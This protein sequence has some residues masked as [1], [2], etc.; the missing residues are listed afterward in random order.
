MRRAPTTGSA[1]PIAPPIGSVPEPAARQH[2]APGVTAAVRV[3]GIGASA[4]GLEAFIDLV[5]A[6]PPQ[7]GLALVLIQHL[8]PHRESLLVDILAGVT[9]NRVREV[10]DGMAIEGDHV[11]VIPPDSEMTVENGLLRLK[12]RASKVPHRPLDSFFCS[13]AQDR[14]DGGIGVVL[15]GNDTDGA[16]GLQAIRDAGGI[17][18]AQT[19]GSARYDVMPRAAAAAADFVLPPAGIAER[20]VSLARRAA[21]ATREG[22]GRPDPAQFARILHLL[23]A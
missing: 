10:A 20:L 1:S 22:N 9:T 17:T 12:P 13:L 5:S 16:F 3:V 18:F 7:T 8:D 11:Y 19:P 21:P 23:R 2:V 4:G 15:S 14:K 6:I